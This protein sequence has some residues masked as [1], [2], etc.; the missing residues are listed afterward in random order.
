MRPLRSRSDLTALVAQH[1][2]SKA[3]A[4]AIF[5][6]RA[7]VLGGFNPAGGLPC[8]IV[9]VTSKHERT[10]LIA[11]DVDEPHHR[12]KIRYIDDVPWE[13]WDGRFNGKRLI[14]GDKPLSCSYERMKARKKCRRPQVR[15]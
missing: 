6:N 13:S 8:F 14:D 12:Y 1:A 2:P 5:E 4:R 7:T 15:Q 3:C 9:R 11:V 10:W